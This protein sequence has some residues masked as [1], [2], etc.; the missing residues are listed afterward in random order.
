MEAKRSSLFGFSVILA[1]MGGL[2]ISC[3]AEFEAEC[4]EGTTQSGGGDADQACIP[5][6]GAG[7]A[8]GATGSVGSAGTE[9][10]GQGGAPAAGSGGSTTAG[11]SG[12]ASGGVGQGGGGAAG[13]AGAGPTALVR[14]A[15]L[16]PDAPAFDVC[17]SATGAF[18][19]P[20]VLKT[21]G[22]ASGLSYARVS[23]YL[24]IELTR[25]R[26]RFVPAGSENC[27]QSLPNVGDETLSTASVDTYSTIATMG[28]IAPALGQ[29]QIKTI[30]YDDRDPRSL[31]PGN[32]AYRFIH[33]SAD[34]KAV[35]LKS[36]LAR[37]V[38]SDDMFDFGNM[39]TQPSMSWASGY[40]SFESSV[41][42]LP[43][44]EHIVS[45]KPS[46]APDDVNYLS[47]DFPMADKE[48]VTGFLVGDFFSS[49]KTLRTLVCFDRTSL[50][51]AAIL[52]TCNLVGLVSDG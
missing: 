32:R 39:P 50:D 10:A 28:K 24:P 48:V 6:A 35:A 43:D 34:M 44:L 27:A 51:S 41:E 5:N 31:T 33:A 29:S 25:N 36:F 3:T 8:G 22:L 7:G 20:P 4:P 9:T 15:H 52:T 17:L 45:N 38:H 18:D 30:R 40:F 11:G 49:P 21:A 1:I 42:N 2:L 26:L 37:P 12:G 19:E 14:F 46:S 47:V 23:V 16:S 13:A